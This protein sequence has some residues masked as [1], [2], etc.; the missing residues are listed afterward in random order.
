[1][2]REVHHLNQIV[3]PHH[4][5]NSQFR[6]V[7]NQISA[8]MNSQRYLDD[9]DDLSCLTPVH[10]LIGEL[11]VQP[12]GANVADIPNNCLSAAERKHV[13]QIFL[14]IDFLKY[15]RNF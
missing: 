8:V 14:T 12:F 7:L 4:L 9:P 5:T 10:F 1:M 6:L 11:I 2:S 13:H 3:G 15:V